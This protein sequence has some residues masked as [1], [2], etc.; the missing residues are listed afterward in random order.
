L[1]ISQKVWSGETKSAARHDTIIYPYFKIF[2]LKKIPK[3]KQFWTLAGNVTDDKN[4]VNKNCEAFQIVNSSL[5]KSEQFFGVDICEKIINLNKE[6]LPNFNWLNGSLSFCIRQ[7]KNFNPAIINLDHHKSP[8]KALPDFFSLISILNRRKIKNCLLIFNSL[9]R[10]PYNGEFYS[11]ED[12]FKSIS[13]NK[14]FGTFSK[15]WKVFNDGYYS[16]NGTGRGKKEMTSLIFYTK[17]E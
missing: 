1:D 13:R 14:E 9:T 4:L 5:I 7:C 2:N 12:L 17:N 3:N 10:N 15:K 11:K 6:K 16:Y 8:Q